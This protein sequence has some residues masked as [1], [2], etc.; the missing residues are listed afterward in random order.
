MLCIPPT[1]RQAAPL[2]VPVILANEHIGHKVNVAQ[3]QRIGHPREH[4]QPAHLVKRPDQLGYSDEE[5][6]LELNDLIRLAFGPPAP[7]RQ[8]KE[9]VFVTLDMATELATATS[10]T[11]EVSVFP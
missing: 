9:A 6:L 3:N 5:E 7:V 1:R 11:A 4:A 10:R 2:V 8:A